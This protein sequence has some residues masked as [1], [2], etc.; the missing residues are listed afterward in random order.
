MI[1][2][3][4]GIQKALSGGLLDIYPRPTEG[5]Y[6]TSAVDLFL[7]SSF[8]GWDQEKLNLPGATVHLDLS[9]QKYQSTARGFLVKLPLENDGSFILKPYSQS[10]RPILAMTR[11]RVHLK[12]GSKLAAR[13]EGRSSLARL[14]LVVHLT[15]P[16][17]HA[18][19]NA[20][21]TLEMINHGPFYLKLVPE[22]TLICQLIVETL[23]SDPAGDIRTDFQHQ[24]SP[25]GNP[26]K[27]LK[28]S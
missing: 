20:P 10:S 14:G 19:F 2:S 18:N 13:V 9:Q 16:T 7:G 27:K 15:A 12:P 26:R 5:Q 25:A 11:E 4:A 17:I 22:K 23:E 3:D 21:I 8:Y 6:T 28:T 1:L 24:E